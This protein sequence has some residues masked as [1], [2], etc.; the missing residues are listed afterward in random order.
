M[1][2]YYYKR[3]L[4]AA[5][6]LLFF[7]TVGM[8]SVHKVHPYYVSVTEIEHSAAEKELQIACKIF[9][10]DLEETLRLAYK[11]K[12]DI[13]HP[14]EKNKTETLLADYLRKHLHIT[15]DGVAMSANFLGFQHEAEAT[16]SFLVV[17]NVS[18]VK[19]IAIDCDVL[20]DTRP[21]QINIFHVKVNGVR[22]SYRL[23]PPAHQF[24][25][26]W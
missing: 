1:V 12:L 7:L 4:P 14:A 9:T 24:E 25:L 19:K 13:I 15:V 5:S 2:R 26:S 21:E 22:K 23:S 6:V 3:F 11:Q 10:D 17:K 16:W 18:T 8:T 20:Y